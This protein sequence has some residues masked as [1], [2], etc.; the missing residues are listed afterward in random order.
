MPRSRPRH[1]PIQT[2]PKTRSRPG[3]RPDPDP[4]HYQPDPAVDWRSTTIDQWLTGGPAVVVAPVTDG[5][6]RGT[7]QVV[8]RGKLIIEIRGTVNR[9]AGMRFR[10]GYVACS[11]WWI[12]LAYE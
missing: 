6:P 5:R 3:L 9:I 8:T 2:R 11:H 7:T 12:Q 4:A 1:D 10:E